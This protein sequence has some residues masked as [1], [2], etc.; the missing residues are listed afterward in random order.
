MS[1]LALSPVP[2]TWL[3]AR[4]DSNTLRALNFMSMNIA[5]SGCVMLDLALL[6][7]YVVQVHLG[8]DRQ[9]HGI[10]MAMA[11]AMASMDK[12]CTPRGGSYSMKGSTVTSRKMPVN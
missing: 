11:L 9:S 2:G 10:G 6:K 8:S 5:I 4:N 7:L 12:E 3:C 1:Q